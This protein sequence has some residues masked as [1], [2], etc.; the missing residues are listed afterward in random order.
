MKGTLDASLILVEL[1]TLLAKYSDARAQRDEGVREW[2]ASPVEILENQHAAE[3]CDAVRLEEELA[4]LNR[5]ITTQIG[6]EA[7]F[8]THPAIKARAK[9]L[10]SLLVVT[11]CDDVMYGVDYALELRSYRALVSRTVN[12]ALR[13]FLISVDGWD[14]GL[15]RENHQFGY[16]FHHLTMRRDVV[17]T[18]VLLTFDPE[19]P[20]GPPDSLFWER[21][22]S[23]APADPTRWSEKRILAVHSAARPSVF[24]PGKQYFRKPGQP[25]FLLCCR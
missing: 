11:V 4:S 16:H 17:R 19:E 21:H 8:V 12:S 25:A 1:G 5:R 24:K 23:Y 9:T 2:R 7:W 14:D 22:G 20:V 3:A 13:L 6:G 15:D 10:A 18:N